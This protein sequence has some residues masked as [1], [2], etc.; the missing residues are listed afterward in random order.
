[1]TFSLKRLNQIE[2]RK[3]EPLVLTSKSSSFYHTSLWAKIWEKSFPAC[4]TLFFI[5]DDQNYIAGLP[6]IQFQKKG[7][8]SF[9]SM[10]FGTY[11]GWIG[12]L[13][14]EEKIKFIQVVVKYCAQQKWLRLQIVDFFD[15]YQELESLK[16][17]KIHT[18]AHVI[19]MQNP[20]SEIGF[21]KRGYE[22]SLKKE[23]VIREICSIDEVRNCYKLYLATTEK[24]QL[25]KIKYPLEFYE[26]IF[27]LGKDT[28]FLKW[29]L[30]LKEN[31]IIAYQINFFFKDMLY[32]WDGAS[33]ASFLS[34]RPNDAL[35]GHSLNRAKE[36]KIRFYNL[37]GSPEKAHGLIK[38]K[39]DW[40]AERKNYFIYEKISAWGKMHNLA[41]KLL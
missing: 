22:Q 29:W 40:G 12:N 11:G 3:W 26:N 2:E 41:R 20:K 13:P 10:P 19:N 31:Q 38:F 34:D 28:K 25:E 36:N 39:E 8:F 4:E 14:V 23:L 16:F 9:F 6:L 21:Q 7:F 5:F 15:Q 32:Y 24:H 27:S 1:M 33:S 35:M 37:G 17:N 30:V 18:F